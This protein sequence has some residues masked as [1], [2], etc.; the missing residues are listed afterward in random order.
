MISHLL[1]CPEQY[2]FRLH[3]LEI[4]YLVFHVVSPLP[5][6]SVP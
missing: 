6:E 1:N 2:Y 3:F 4:C 5:R